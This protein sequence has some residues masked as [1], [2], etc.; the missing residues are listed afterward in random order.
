M[1]AVSVRFI[2]RFGELIGYQQG[3]VGVIAS[4][5]AIGIAVAV[6]SLNAV[7]IFRYNITVWVHAE[8]SDTVDCREQ[9]GGEGCDGEGSGEPN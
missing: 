2:K 7:N 8:G 4:Q 3:K 5:V 6:N 1:L 9:D